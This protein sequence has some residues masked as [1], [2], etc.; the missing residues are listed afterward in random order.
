MHRVLRENNRAVLRVEDESHGLKASEE[1]LAE[2]NTRENQR[3]NPR[4]DAFEGL[5]WSAVSKDF[6]PQ[7]FISGVIHTYCHI[8]IGTPLIGIILIGVGRVLTEMHR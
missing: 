1:R 3:R 7:V 5:I 8:A 2:S 6:L 4:N